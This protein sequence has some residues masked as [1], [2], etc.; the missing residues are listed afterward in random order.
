[1]GRG[2]NGRREKGRGGEKSE[3]PASP[4]LVSPACLC[5]HKITANNE[6]SDNKRKERIGEGGNGWGQEGIRGKGGEGKG[7]EGN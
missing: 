2:G 3:K 1:V 6:E 7:E 5:G 4:P